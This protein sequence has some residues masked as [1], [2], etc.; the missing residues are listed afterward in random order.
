MRKLSILIFAC[1]A[2]PTFAEPNFSRQTEIVG[3]SSIQEKIEESG[4]YCR[5]IQLAA[6]TEGA[7]VPQ[8][9]KKLS[10]E[11]LLDIGIEIQK[12]QGVVTISTKSIFDKVEVEK[13]AQSLLTT[14]KDIL[15]VNCH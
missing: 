13:L 6:Y 3:E 4:Q 7:N 15:V 5:K 1:L 12:N 2:M 14:N 10:T 11:K 9:M 8:G